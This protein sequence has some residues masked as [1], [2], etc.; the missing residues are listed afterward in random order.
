M[1][2]SWNM[3]DHIGSSDAALRAWGAGQSAAF[4]AAGLVK[5]ASAGTVDWTTA[6]R[7][8]AANTLIGYE[9]WAL[10]DALQP[11][12]PVYLRFEFW[13]ASTTAHPQVRVTVGFA[14]DGPTGAITGNAAAYT[15]Y[16]LT[17][18]V[19]S[20]YAQYMAGDGSGFVWHNYAAH[21][22]SGDGTVFV[23]ER[24]R[25]AAGALDGRGVIV[26]KF[27]NTPNTTN[28]SSFLP[29]TGT[30][31]AIASGTN[32]CPPLSGTGTS[33]NTVYLFPIRP[34]GFEEQFPFVL[35]AAYF[36]VDLTPGNPVPV[37]GWDGVT[38]TM[39]PVALGS[40]DS[41]CPALPLLTMANVAQT[42]IF[43]GD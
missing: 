36:P 26:G 6:V 20:S 27:T 42:A 29:R 32:C 38:R 30:P 28:K 7:P 5:Q 17:S 1:K 3:V 9:V 40:T 37:T 33:G 41:R 2:T 8:V 16:L 4:A 13:S 19:G 21:A 43:W 31:E 11:T 12:Y 39:N 14:F 25:N 10:N 34:M 18:A 23:L 22:N 35:V 15:V 24:T